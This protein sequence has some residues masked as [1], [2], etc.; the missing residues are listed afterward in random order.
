LSALGIGAHGVG[1]S[2]NILMRHAVFFGFF[3]ASFL[4][5]SKRGNK[6]VAECYERIAAS[7]RARKS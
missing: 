1:C 6:M 4:S 5:G 3:L 2:G 7:A